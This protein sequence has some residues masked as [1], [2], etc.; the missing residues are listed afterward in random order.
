MK[1]VHITYRFEYNDAIEQILDQCQVKEF[2]RYSMVE[3]QTLDGKHYGTQVFP[4]NLNVVQ[5][6]VPEEK[7]NDLFQQLKQF[8]QQKSSHQHIQAVVLPVERRI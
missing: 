3:G 2:A 8:Q 1:F 6:Q 4:G 7:L 5:A